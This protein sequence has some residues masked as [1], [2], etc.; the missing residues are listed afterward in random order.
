MRPK[1]RLDHL[2]HQLFDAEK[3]GDDKEWVQELEAEI[4]ELEQ[5]LTNLNE[6]NKE[7]QVLSNKT[8]ESQTPQE[9]EREL[10]Q[11]VKISIAS[12]TPQSLAIEEALHNTKDKARKKYLRN[13]L[14]RR[15]K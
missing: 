7:I 4:E 1:E 15:L 9:V 5:T 13:L 8:T 2:K 12:G 11:Q 3:I 10:V 14:L 6:D